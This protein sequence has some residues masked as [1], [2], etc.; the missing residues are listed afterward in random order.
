MGLGKTSQVISLIAHL[1]EN[2]ETGPHLIIVPS[3][4]LDNW[5]REFKRWWVSRIAE[6]ISSLNSLFVNRVPSDLY[7]K[8]YHGSQSER[9]HLR[10]EILA[11]RS[12][13]V[14]LTTY[15]IATGSKED[16]SFLRKMKFKS[17]ILDEG[18]MIKNVRYRRFL[19][20][21][22]IFQLFI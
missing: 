10:E 5:L 14:I 19:D 6:F 1:L 11:S 4:T 16:R 22:A 7:V 8:P 13:H 15:N 17:M 9:F 12:Y 21:V 3:S 18:H 20:T 2:G